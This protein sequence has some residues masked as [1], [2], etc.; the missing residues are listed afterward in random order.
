MGDVISEEKLEK[1]FSVTKQALD[2]IAE[3][4]VDEAQKGRAEEVLD[5]AKRYYDDAGHFREK[6]DWVLAFAALNYAHGWL[7]CGARLGLF[8]VADSKLF[9]VDDE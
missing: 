2:M 6:G 3:K 5:M 8:K 9:T 1:Y 4:G 7:D